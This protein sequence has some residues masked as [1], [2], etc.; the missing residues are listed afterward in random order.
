M[1]GQKHPLSAMRD[2][3]S[4]CDVP[5]EMAIPGGLFLALDIQPSVK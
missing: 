2:N 3:P 1:V 4:F 5:V